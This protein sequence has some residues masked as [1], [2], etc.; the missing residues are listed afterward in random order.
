MPKPGVS[1][2]DLAEEL[3]YPDCGDLQYLEIA[4]KSWNKWETITF[5]TMA[6]PFCTQG[7]PSLDL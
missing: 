6:W 7:Y 1:C 4:M 5:E 2:Q 3:R